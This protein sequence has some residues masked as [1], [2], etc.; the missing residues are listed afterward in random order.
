MLGYSIYHVRYQ[1]E[2][3][4]VYLKSYIQDIQQYTV[5]YSAQIW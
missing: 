3:L 5:F 1:Q 2:Y 4:Y